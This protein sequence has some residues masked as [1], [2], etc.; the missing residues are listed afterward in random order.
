MPQTTRVLAAATTL[1]GT[2]GAGVLGSGVA[3]AAADTAAN[4]VVPHIDYW[5]NVATGDIV[6]GVRSIPVS[7]NSLGLTGG[8]GTFHP[9]TNVVGTTGSL[10]LSSAP[11]TDLVSSNGRLD[12]LAPI[13]VVGG[14]IPER[15]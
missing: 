12:S 5:S 7:T 6:H 2:V 1:A 8:Y 15:L 11:V 14:L 9:L 3:T 10:P 4:A 13:P